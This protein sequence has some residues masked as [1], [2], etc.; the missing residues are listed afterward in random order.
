M[1]FKSEDEKKQFLALFYKLGFD[2]EKTSFQIEE[3]VLNKIKSRMST[4]DFSLT[5]NEKLQ[6]KTMSEVISKTRKE[7]L[8]FFQGISLKVDLF[9]LEYDPYDGSIKD[10]KNISSLRAKYRELMQLFNSKKISAN[11]VYEELLEEY[12][13]HSKKGSIFQIPIIEKKENTEMIGLTHK[14]PLI[15]PGDREIL[16]RVPVYM[17]AI[18]L[19]TKEINLLNVG[20]YAHELTHALLDRHKGVVENYYND[21]LLS[22]FMEKLFV[23]ALD[24][25]KNKRVLKI[26]EIRRLENLKIAFNELENSEGESYYS[27]LKYI[28]STLYAGILFDKYSRASKEEK[29]KMIKLI[30]EILNGRRKVND[31]LQEE[32]IDLSEDVINQ[33]IGKV[34]SYC[35]EIEGKSDQD[36]E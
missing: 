18:F 35:K 29:D 26:S 15:C 24:T 4:I 12:K 16:E 1:K 33:Y 23:D 28:Q 25:S 9:D 36:Y 11:Q 30:G 14:G 3:S 32:Q 13:S 20:T 5:K 10:S 31:L 2:P 7:F 21:E 6:H 19:G 34:E 17:E 8:S 27:H 22:I